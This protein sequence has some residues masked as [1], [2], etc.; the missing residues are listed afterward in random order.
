[1]CTA[2]QVEVVRA[3]EVC[4]FILPKAHAHSSVV[5]DPTRS[6]R[7]WVG[8]DQVADESFAVNDARTDDLT[9]FVNFRHFVAD[10]SMDAEDPVGDDCGEGEAVEAG[11]KGLPEFD[12]VALF[13]LIEEAV[14]SGDLLAFVVPSQQ[15]KAL[16]VTDLIGQQQADGL[17]VLFPPVHIIA[18]KQVVRLWRKAPIMKETQQIEVLS[19][20]VACTLALP[21]PQMFTGASRSNTTGC[22]IITALASLIRAM[23]SGSGRLTV[24]PGFALSEYISCLP[25]H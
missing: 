7:V 23:I 6:L 4:D 20:D 19:M 18:Q 9:D 10:A 2:Y 16:A 13:A 22:F 14:N 21:I 17:D 1:M 5:L 15:E 24:V 12:T 3:Q 11:H 25:D 8:P